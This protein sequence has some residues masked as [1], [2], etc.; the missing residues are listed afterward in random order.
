M[1]GTRTDHES[2]T[3]GKPGEPDPA[4]VGVERAIRADQRMSEEQQTALSGVY[5]TMLGPVS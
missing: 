3:D 5:R 2:G 1:T 4:G